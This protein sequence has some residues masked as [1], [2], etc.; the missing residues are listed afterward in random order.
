[1]SG[2]ADAVIRTARRRGS[3]GLSSGTGV[4]PRH[5]APG[6]MALGSSWSK[7]SYLELG[8]LPTAVPCARWKA[9]QMLWEWGLAQAGESNQD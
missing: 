3:S 1:M 8:A 9:K 4:A 7:V 6:F 2:H 5:Q